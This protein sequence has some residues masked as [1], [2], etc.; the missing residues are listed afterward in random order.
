MHHESVKMIFF[1]SF[2]G[3]LAD[4]HSSNYIFNCFAVPSSVFFLLVI[5]GVPSL[6]F[7]QTQVLATLNSRLVIG[8]RKPLPYRVQPGLLVE[9][10]CT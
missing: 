4:H 9:M 2:W 8:Y 6:I 10:R 3:G 1:Y 5:R 7:A